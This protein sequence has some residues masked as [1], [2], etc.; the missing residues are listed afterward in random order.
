M[1]MSLVFDCARVYLCYREWGNRTIVPGDQL[2]HALWYSVHGSIRCSQSSMFP[3]SFCHLSYF[4][5]NHRL[6][7]L[8]LALK[9]LWWMAFM[10]RSRKLVFLALV[11]VNR[12][13]SWRVAKLFART[14]CIASTFLLLLTRYKLYCI[15]TTYKVLVVLHYYYL[16]GISCIVLLLLTMY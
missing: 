3:C 14:S 7:W 1:L 10:L 4:V 13:L 2:S 11:L 8:W 15:I 6:N 5:L 16:Q 12:L 9:C